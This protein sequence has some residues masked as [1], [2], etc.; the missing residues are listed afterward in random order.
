MTAIHDTLADIVA[1]HSVTGNEGRLCTAVAQRLLK[2]WTMQGVTRIGNALV[3]GQQTGRPLITLFG[4]LDT[5]PVQDN[6]DPVIKDG[7]MYGLGTVDM[8]SGLAIMI[9][10]LEDD[11]VR[12]GP[13]DV[14]GVFYDKEEGPMADNGLEV[15][16]DTAPWLVDSEFAIVLEPTNLG[17]E[18]GCNGA[19]NA[20]VFFEGKAA[21][22]ARPWLGENAVTKA[23]SWLAEMHEREPELVEIDGLEY[24][25]VF[26]VTAAEGGIANN[27][28]PASMRINLNYR[29]PPIYSLD[30]AEDRLRQVATEADYV[31]VKDRAPAGKVVENNPHLDRLL[32]LSGAE[33]SSKQGWTD[34]ARLTERG[35]PAINYGPGDPGL[36]HQQAESVP[37][38]N[39]DRGFE[40]LR[41]FLI[42]GQEDS[43]AELAELLADD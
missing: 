35:I 17:V 18:L 42:D 40:V 26:S 7:R 30:E 43:S 3:V 19:M 28:L 32:A 23:G 11:A 13:Y 2:V 27:V 34:V 41:E 6:G 29:F 22:S 1:V 12:S 16:L 5:V 15:V 4:H 24:R 14:V 21:H 33:R 9:H 8:K 20:D 25:E 10:L 31:V 39:V 36:A 37:L 38:I